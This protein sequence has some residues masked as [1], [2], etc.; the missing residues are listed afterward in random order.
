MG[1]NSNNN[2][3]LVRFESDEE[4]DQNTNTDNGISVVTG[5]IL[6]FSTQVT[7]CVDRLTSYADSV[8][9]NEEL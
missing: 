2:V 9:A 1:Y 8:F 4:T 5:K 3:K 7:C 6:V